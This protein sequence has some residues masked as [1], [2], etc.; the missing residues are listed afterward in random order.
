MANQILELRFIQD[1]TVSETAE[2]LNKS[3]LAVR[4]TQHRALKQLRKILKKEI[5]VQYT[6]I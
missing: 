2:I 3:N 4:L 6:E 1:F 5:D